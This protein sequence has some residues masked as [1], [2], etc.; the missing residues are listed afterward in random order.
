[1]HQEPTMTPTSSPASGTTRRQLIRTGAFGAAATALLAACGTKSDNRA[2]Q[3]GVDPTTTIAAPEAPIPDISAAD[4]AYNVDLLRTAT[5]LEL[6]AADLY[7]EY[8]KELED[9]EWKASAARFATDHAAAA[10]EFQA[11]TPSDARVDEPNE[12]LQTNTVDPFADQLTNDPAILDIFAAMESTIVAT[13]IAA[14]GTYTQ[15]EGRARFAGFAEAAARRNAVM[16][17]AGKGGFPTAALY[18]LQD[19]IPNEAYVTVASENPDAAGAD[20]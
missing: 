1:M 10:E 3:S 6:L 20:E 13:Y 4:I 5:S 18:P 16:A 19:L 15:V 7:E 14:V 11:A 12:F 2:G 9:A 8:G 17:N